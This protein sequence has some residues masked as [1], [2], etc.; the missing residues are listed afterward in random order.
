MSSGQRKCTH[1]HCKQC[2]LLNITPFLTFIFILLTLQ[3]TK[4]GTLISCCRNETMRIPE[5]KEANPSKAT[6]RSLLSKHS[7]ET[8]Q[9]TTICSSF[10]LNWKGRFE[11]RATTRFHQSLVF[12]IKSGTAWPTS[13]CAHEAEKP[14]C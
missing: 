11:F 9:R 2:V 13:R 12:F 8:R 7:R 5:Q 4:A 6:P 3:I 10:Y 1:S 14:G